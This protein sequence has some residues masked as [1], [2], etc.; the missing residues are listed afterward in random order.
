MTRA[1]SAFPLAALAS[2]AV[3]AQPA[4]AQEIRINADGRDDA[5]VRTE[6]GR[7]A[8]RVCKAADREGAFQGAY[9][10]QNCLMDSQRAAVLQLKAYRREAARSASTRLA[11]IGPPGV[12]R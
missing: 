6:I 9:R 2:L 11:R 1:L 12:P 8:E 4:G 3:V 7:A 10:L 5:S